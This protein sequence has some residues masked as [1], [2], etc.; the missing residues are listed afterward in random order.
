M[1]SLLSQALACALALAISPM[2]IGADRASRTDAPAF[3]FEEASIAQLQER[4]AENRLT[5]R[6]LVDAYLRRI[7]EID[8]AGPTLNAV[9]EINPEA[10]R[11]AEARDAERR[12]GRVRG[13]LHGI[14]VL[15]KDN[16][17]AVPMVNSAG[18]LALAAHRPKQDAFLVERLR[19]AGAVILGKTNLSEWAN[20]RSTRG[21]SGWSARGGQTRNPY[22]LDRNPCGSSSGSGVAV[23]AN[24]AAAAVG[25]ETD[26]SILCPAAVNGVVGIKP[27]VGLIS[28]SGI[29]PISV[30]QDT[31]GPMARSVADA[32]ALLAAMTAADPAD[33]T[34]GAAP[35]AKPDYLAA[36]DPQALQGARIGVLR[37]ATGYHPGV[38]A[39][40]ERALATLRA[41]GAELVDVEI[42]TD[43][44]WRQAEY[45]VLL[46]EFRDGIGR[47][48]AG[49]GAPVASLE[50]LIAFNRSQAAAEMPWFGQEI[51][52]MA[53]AVGPIN[54]PAYLEARVNARRLAGAEGIDAT[55]TANRLVALV[56][57]TTGP[58]WVTD[59]VNGDHFA[60]A[61][62]GAAAVAGTPS[63]TVPMGHVHG[64]PV[65]LVL[66]GPA[67]SEA[68]LIGFAHAFEQRQRART[69]PQFLPTI[70][71][72]ATAESADAAA[73][74]QAR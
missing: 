32:A 36:L 68:R 44:T 72:P 58:A 59:P 64:L 74:S 33:P 19:D 39:E 63:I 10:R 71:A 69:A 38:D 14:P 56:A 3:A 57:P 17:D 1:P 47:Y 6:A 29:I 40:F 49:S 53:Q 51:L 45:A 31:A 65:G 48:L 46:H 9:I 26:G 7:A 12:A 54:A 5:S 28:R 16:I 4:M 70:A 43:G 18:S 52:E 60:G 34:T 11:E 15:L 2:A 61:G 30:S 13:P 37:K 35:S 62:Y 8:D 42:A 24:L 50:A 73:S 20:F 67:W 25:T 41:A 66:L 55:L 27:T 21:T 22:A 23:S